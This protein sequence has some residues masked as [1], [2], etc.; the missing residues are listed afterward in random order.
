MCC[1]DATKGD[2]NPAQLEAFEKIDTL[3]KGALLSVLDDSIVD[4]YVSFD[5]GKD[6]WFA[7]DAKWCL[8]RRQRVV[9][10]GAII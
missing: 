5:N 9:R 8:G 3:F 2:L 4:S 1:Y 7:L 6:M 10:H